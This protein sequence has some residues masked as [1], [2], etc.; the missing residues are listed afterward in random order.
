[1][2]N[3]PYYKVYVNIHLLA[4]LI[5]GILNFD[6][7]IYW[8]LIV[9]IENIFSSNIL[10]FIAYKRILKTYVLQSFCKYSFFLADVMVEI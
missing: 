10:Y 5:T 9:D 7:F 1:M 6:C 8:E 2:K 3:A 4:Y